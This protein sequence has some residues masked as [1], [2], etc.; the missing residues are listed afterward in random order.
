MRVLLYFL[1]FLSIE[2]TICYGQQKEVYKIHTIAFYNLENLFDHL[3]DP[4]TFDNDRT[5]TGK[6][7]WTA[8]N[9]H[10]KLKNMARVIAE[11]GRDVTGTAP[12]IFGVCEIEN[13]TVLEELLNQEPLI[14]YNY[15]I[16][17]FD[18]PDRRGIDVALLYQK[19]IFTP[20]HYKVLPLLIY[21][22]NDTSKRI[23]TRDQL[24]VSGML[25]GEQIHIIVNHWPSRSGGEARSRPKRIKAA[26][27][28]RRII[29]SLF[30]DNPYAKI[31]TMG[32]LND[33]PISPS[34]KKVLKT[35]RKQNKVPLK[36]L[37]NPMEEMYKL[38]LGTLA[39]RDNWNLF[40]QIIVSEA[41]LKKDY[42]TYQFYKAGIYN[43][44]YLIASTGP[45]A[46]Y[47]FRS[48]TDGGFTGGF[49]D[50][51]PV[52]IYLIKNANSP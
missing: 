19:K 48:F 25:D 28:N 2:N 34:V 1:A 18:S 6:D 17:H 20:T 21:D 11:I 23:Y 8:E 49:S 26:T 13:R 42:T 46:G 22:D 14:N 27:L 38:G 31:I 43:Q 51:F 12:V 44:A 9:Y 35:E 15:G 5:P 45:Y 7:H 40:D 29:D 47:P 39:W 50:H 4:I 10:A 37:Y 3:D 36:G 16:V 24:V 30:S 33:D 41:F 32:D 52:Y